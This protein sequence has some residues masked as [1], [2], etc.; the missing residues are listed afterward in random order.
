MT[1]R[2]I[3]LLLISLLVACTP[4]DDNLVLPTRAVM[5][6]IM[7]A[8]EVFV[9]Q[10][11]TL[12]DM[13]QV[14][15]W[16]FI[17]ESGR[18]ARIRAVMEANALPELTLIYQGE[19]IARGNNLIVTLPA[20]AVYDV[21]VRLAQGNPSNYEI[22]LRY[23]ERENPFVPTNTPV[24]QVVGVP[25][26][27]AAFNNLGTFIQQLNE[28][29]EVSGVLTAQSPQQVYTIAGEAGEVF[30]FELRR[31]GGTLD[32]VLRFYNPA[33]D[34]LAFDDDSLSGV[35]AR[36]LNITLPSSGLYSV[37]VSGKSFFGDY[38]LYFL[39]GGMSPRAAQLPTLTPSPVPTFATPAI[40]PAPSDSRLLNHVPII[41]EIE[42]EGGFQ[43]FSFNAE[44]GQTV[45]IHATP[46]GD[47][48][49]SPEMQVFDP[50]GL[51]LDTLPQS[52]ASTA[53]LG[54]VAAVGAL[55]IQQTGT[56]VIIV[57][58]E[59]NTTGAY[60][61]GFGRGGSMR[62][63]FKGEP[64]ENA[65]AGSRLQAGTRDIWRLPLQVGDAISLA[66]SP[67]S[68][69]LDPVIEIATAD[70]V[71]AFSDDNSGANN[72]ALIRLAEIR[73]PATYVLRIYDANGTGSGEYTL[74]WRYVD[75]APTATPRP[76]SIPILTV[77]GSIS[78]NQYQFYRFQG[79]AGQQLRIQVD[80]A[81]TS[82]LDPVLAV[83][84]PEGQVIAE[85]DDTNGLN[86]QVDL[87]LPTD[88]TYSVRVNGYLSSGTFMLK[89][90]ILLP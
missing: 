17:G 31:I 28:T 83:L 84:D 75:R 88:G 16:Q 26:P 8:L 69:T 45:T 53:S 13:E 81:E 70:G 19:V 3:I 52:K 90:S 34:V 50:D 86:P 39:R 41:A 82:L 64:L 38:V 58:G 20:D 46:Y 22:G 18:Q 43:R 23:D 14:D 63:A 27:T 61:I 35:D 57:T 65:T 7:G 15:I 85:A 72:A 59:G 62:E 32:P 76:N 33:G 79:Q 2:H 25:T 37:Q 42:R 54:G 9:P 89:A 48:T 10:S 21:Q 56:Y 4:Q 30:T 78:Q 49:L 80:A 36:L 51:L 87:T 11:G 60:T 68:P 29:T 74:L 44:A 12:N 67:N 40:V 55:Q 77:N 1:W 24:Q 71:V 6:N 66:V 73:Q 5:P 47:R